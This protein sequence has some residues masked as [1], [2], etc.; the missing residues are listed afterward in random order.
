MIRNK[1]SI[2]AVNN[3]WCFDSSQSFS[4]ASNWYVYAILVIPFIIVTFIHQKKKFGIL[5]NKLYENCDV[6]VSKL[7]DVQ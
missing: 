1:F 5:H 4:K 3:G 2:S 6:V 7:N